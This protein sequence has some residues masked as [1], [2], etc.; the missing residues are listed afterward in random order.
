MTT[1]TIEDDT[2]G[3][4]VV[5]TMVPAGEKDEEGN[6][7]HVIESSSSPDLEEIIEK[8]TNIYKTTLNR[9]GMSLGVFRM[10]PQP[11]KE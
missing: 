2:T 1:V 11:E 3:E 10:R 4:K 7:N 5:F 6:Q 8:S 9:L